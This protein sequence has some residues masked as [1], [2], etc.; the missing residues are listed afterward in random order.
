MKEFIKET[1]KDL[2][3]R[4]II[5]IFQ[6]PNIELYMDQVTTFTEEKLEAYKTNEEDK[7]LT[8]TM[9]NNYTKAGL[10]EPPVKKKYS[11]KNIETLIMIF[12]FKYILSINDVKK[13]TDI[14]CDDNITQIYEEFTKIQKR[15]EEEIIKNVDSIDFEEDDLQIF[16]A[17]CALTEGAVIRKKLA[18]KIIGKYL[19]KND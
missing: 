18:E 7:I 9:I 14:I 12:H 17:V 3:E 19:G 2:A 6:I 11:K 4:S 10:I 15:E 5:D 16:K 8:K 1:I 13:L